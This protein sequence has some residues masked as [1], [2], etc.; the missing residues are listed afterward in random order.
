MI[1]SPL[2]T[3]LL[4]E[5]LPG[6]TA[7]AT[8]IA[9]AGVT[10]LTVEHAAYF[11]IFLVG[12]GA[13]LLGLGSAPFSP[14]EAAAAWPA[15]LDAIALPVENAPQPVSAL[16][17]TLQTALF[18]L[19]GASSETLARLPVALVACLL[20]VLPWYWRRTLGRPAALFLALLLALDPWLITLARTS[21]SALLSVTLAL[22]CLTA[23]QS[24][25]AGQGE[26]GSSRALTLA[27]ISAG[28]LL[29]SGP[30][31]W[32]WAVALVAYVILALPQRR[33]DLVRP[34][35]LALLAGAALL[36]ATV[37]LAQPQALSMVGASLG[38]WTQQLAAGPYTLS[39]PALRL[40]VDQPFLL[41]FGVAGL[42][43][44]LSGVQGAAAPQRLFLLVW[45]AWAVLLLLLPGRSV[46]TL[47]LL[48]VA[49]AVLAALAL[50]RL[51]RVAEGERDWREAGLL[52]LV[53]VVLLISQLFW[54]SALVW[55]TPFSATLA[56]IVAALFLLAAGL[57]AGFAI[58]VNPRQALVLA[59]GVGALFLLGA[60][61]SSTWRLAYNH[62][63]RYPDG[64][65]AEEGVR[66][67]RAL[68]VDVAAL[69]DIRAGLDTELAVQVVT[70]P[71]RIPDPQLGWLLRSMR[72]LSFVPAPQVVAEPGSARLPLVLMASDGNSAAWS[73]FYTGADYRLRRSW[74]PSALSASGD[75]ADWESR[76]AGS[77][78]PWLRWMLQ[79]EARAGEAQTINLWA[80]P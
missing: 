1:N 45:P 80:T 40:L 74:L 61:L 44:L 8:P 21:D 18:W 35:A 37:W 32:S 17:H 22:L 66:D 65:F 24:L 9:P 60:S 68:A 31:A 53:L 28:L 29:A 6:P 67:A 4:E 77:V 76:W 5:R 11:V 7:A 19:L 13:R 2:A 25:S 30:Q 64:F 34:H 49:L 12:A 47:P 59:A 70:G 38:V 62:D 72:N 71:S 52:A 10:S 69:S 48:G 15:W 46:Q 16:L 56:A 14:A 78:R 23:L 42:V 58:F 27:A 26:E 63:S 50:Q 75:F 39:W 43:V 73:E 57:P 51:L 20:P 79:R 3:P 33:G 36:G 54:I 41:V 55:A